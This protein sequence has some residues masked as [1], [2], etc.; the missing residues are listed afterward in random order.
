MTT[1]PNMRCLPGGLQS[2]FDRETFDIHVPLSQEDLRQAHVSAGLEVIASGYLM[3]CNFSALAG[4]KSTLG[5][6]LHKAF[7]AVSVG[8]WLLERLKLAPKPNGLTSPY[9]YCVARRPVGN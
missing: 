7:V 8:T 4:P 1:I 9:V 6:C 5:Q 2:W 3:F